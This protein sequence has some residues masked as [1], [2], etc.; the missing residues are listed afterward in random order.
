MRVSRV[1]GAYPAAAVRAGSGADRLPRGSSTVVRR[2]VRGGAVL[3]DGA[4]AAAP[5]SGTLRR[6]RDGARGCLKGAAGGLPAPEAPRLKQAMPWQGEGLR[7][8]CT[9]GHVTGTP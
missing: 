3:R 7:R 6:G 8:P 1:G 5:L 4:V 2:R 9:C